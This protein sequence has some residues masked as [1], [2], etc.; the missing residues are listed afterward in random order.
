M[1]DPKRE[2][3][4]SLDLHGIKV[5]NEHWTNFSEKHKMWMRLLN[6]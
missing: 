1:G 3:L 4:S 6:N 2:I 5:P